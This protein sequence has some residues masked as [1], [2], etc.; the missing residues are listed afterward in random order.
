MDLEMIRELAMPILRR[1]DI[2]KAFIFGSYSKGQQKEYSDIDF[3]IEYSPKAKRSLLTLVR[4]KNE[5][6]EAL[7]KEVDVVTENALS[8][9]LKDRV[10]KDKRVVM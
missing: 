4:L 8:P 10:L 2:E 3:L 7:K 9:Y 1:Y 6:E 5:L